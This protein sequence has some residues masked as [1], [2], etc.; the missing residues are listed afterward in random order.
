[1]CSSYALS[2]ATLAV[3]W[4]SSIT[5]AV[6]LSSNQPFPDIP[7]KVFVEFIGENFS[8]KISLVTVLVVLLSMTENTQLLNLHAR[9]QNPVF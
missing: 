8:S 5:Q 7:F 4:N 2:L 3:L 9:Q 1:M 6:A